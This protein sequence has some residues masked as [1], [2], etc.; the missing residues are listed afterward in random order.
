MRRRQFLKAVAGAALFPWPSYASDK[1][2]L[3]PGVHLYT[4]YQSVAAGQTIR[5]HVSSS[6]PYVLS[7]VRL[8]PQVDDPAADE[9][10]HEFPK[11]PAA[12]QAIH[13]GSYVQVDKSFS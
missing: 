12:I 5:F 8:G 10:L 13:P 1:P 7:V 2:L 6:V 4:G 11:A 3:V 9:V